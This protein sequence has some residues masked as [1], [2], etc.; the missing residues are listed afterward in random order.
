[1][2]GDVNIGL[3]ATRHYWL[4]LYDV[5]TKLGFSVVVINPLQID[6]YRKSGIRKMKN[7]ST[8]SI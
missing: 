4:S 2:E 7:D 1:M 3:E 6:A 5:L 8:D